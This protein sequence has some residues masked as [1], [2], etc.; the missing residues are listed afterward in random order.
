MDPKKGKKVWDC[1][2]PSNRRELW[3]IL[4]V[5]IF[6][7]KFDLELSS[8]S[9][10][11]LELQGENAPWRW[12]DTYTRAQE[13]IK[14]LVNSPQILKPWNH[15]SETPK[16]LVCD[17]S[18]IRLGSWIG[19]GELGSIWPCRFHYRKFSPTQLKYPTYQKELLT[20]VDSLK[21]FEAQLQDH[22][23][24]VLTD[25]QP[26]LSFLR[27]R[28][29]SQKL[30][31]WQTYMGEFHLLIQHTGGKENL[32]AD[33]LSTK[34]KY[35]LDPTKKQDFIPQSIDSTEDNTESQATSIATNNLSISLIPKEITMVFCCCINFKYTNCEYN[36]CAGWDE[37]LSH[38]PSYSYLDDGDDRDYED[39]Y[40]IKEEEM[41]SD[42][43]TLSNIPQ[44]IF[45]R[46]EFNPHPQVVEH[47]QL[48]S[49]DN[50]STPAYDTFS[51]T[52]D[53]IFPPLLRTLLI[54][55]ENTTSSMESN[56]IWMVTTTT[57]TRIVARTKMGTT[58]FLPPDAQFAEPID[59]D[60]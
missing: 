60:V 48:N 8:S 10:I 29:T 24:T 2:V 36:K 26:L 51:A 23:F 13:K 37:S 7:R 57:A 44:E 47:D 34:H 46:Y 19:Q 21:Y 54:I 55:P 59:M 28:Q 31:H 14:E 39:E 6:L 42:K 20:I 18:D 30:A 9:R 58:I 45:D 5:V 35:C 22:K 40:N 4:V 17:A 25:H 43:D 38:Y 15:F 53:E 33:P 52:N 3:A 56:I 50:I 16:Y 32:L 11:L 27:P 1:K 12:M 49:Y 41:R